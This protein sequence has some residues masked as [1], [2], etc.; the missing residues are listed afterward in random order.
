VELIRDRGL[1]L[2]LMDPRDFA[3]VAEV[4]RQPDHRGDRQELTLPVLEWP[5]ESKTVHA[6][7]AETGH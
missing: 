6:P 4:H 2:A 7:H 1:T 5:P 3:I